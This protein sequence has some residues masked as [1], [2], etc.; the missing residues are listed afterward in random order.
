MPYIWDTVPTSPSAPVDQPRSRR[1]PVTPVP[2]PP[3]WVDAETWLTG[4]QVGISALGAASAAIVFMWRAI[5]HW[6][7]KMDA[8]MAHIEAEQHRADVR[9]VTLE[10]FG[11]DLERLTQGIDRIEARLEEMRNRCFAH[12]SRVSGGAE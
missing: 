4:W 2:Q 10:A 6:T 5:S 1:S 8:R 12:M 7:G 9:I 3:E 11:R